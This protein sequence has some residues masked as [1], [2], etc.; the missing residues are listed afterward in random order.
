MEAVVSG[1]QVLGSLLPEWD[2]GQYRAAL[3][4]VNIRQYLAQFSVS[5]G[6]AAF[7][8]SLLKDFSSRSF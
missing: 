4:W 6:L 3:L 8:T 1:N 2:S 5:S 7:F